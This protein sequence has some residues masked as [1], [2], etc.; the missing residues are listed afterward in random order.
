M[1]RLINKL[2][3]R[4]KSHQ[5]LI[6]KYAASDTVFIY[7][8]GKVGSTTLENSLPNAVHL[9]AFY[10]KN[11]T[12]PVRLFGLRKLSLAHAFYTIEQE[13][14][15]WYIRRVFKR[16]RQQGKVTKIITLVREPL[17]RNQS[18]FFHDLDAYLYMAHTNCL[19]TRVAAIPT[20][21]QTTRLLSDVFTQEFNHEYAANWFDK[22]F[23]PMTGIN[24]YQYDFD[25][26][27]GVSRIQEKGIDILCL[28]CEKIQEN[29]KLL[30]DFV[31]NT[32]E[33]SSTNKAEDKW[34]GDLYKQ[35]KADYAL[36]EGVYKKIY[37]SRFYQHFFT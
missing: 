26:E 4:F 18:M 24:I 6:L 22:E 12:C 30:S 14:L 7:Q 31:G 27:R 3:N 1:L 28:N 25:K 36:P 11:H 23:L 15:W 29:E 20:R 17:S 8:M 16:R 10:S 35:F 34:Y 5:A 13:L 37:T 2:K 19:N 9:H 33:V 21:C 32:I